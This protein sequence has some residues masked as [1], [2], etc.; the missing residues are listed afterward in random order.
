MVYVK[1]IIAMA[2]AWYLGFLSQIFGHPTPSQ[3]LTVT[4][5]SADGQLLEQPFIKWDKKMLKSYAQ[6]LMK[7]KYPMWDKSE[8]RALKKLWGKESA[9]NHKAKN[10]H[11][12]AFGVPQLLKLDTNTPAPLQIERGLEYI[13]H[14]YG[15]PSVAWQHW[16]KKK[17]Y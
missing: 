12:S 11:S 15:K 7:V 8:F 6:T 17:W 3:A 16:R 9:W 13:E 2:M 10:P 14:R 1:K 4:L 5:D